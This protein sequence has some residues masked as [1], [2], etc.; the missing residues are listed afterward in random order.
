MDSH[1]S[2]CEAV[3]PA[4]G[5]YL[6]HLREGL[7]NPSDRTTWINCP[8]TA[9]LFPFAADHLFTAMV[10]NIS[11]RPIKMSCILRFLDLNSG[12]RNISRTVTIAGNDVEAL[13]WELSSR[14]LM[15]PN[16]NCKL[17]PGGAIAGI[18]AMTGLL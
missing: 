11:N 17:P 4:N 8:A 12:F 16:I 2:A 15:M 10:Y 1:A 14:W 18:T 9:E 13:F 3:R 6:V 7:E 5:H